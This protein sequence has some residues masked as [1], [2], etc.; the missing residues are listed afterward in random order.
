MHWGYTCRKDG[1]SSAFVKGV[2]GAICASAVAAVLSLGTAKNA[3]AMSEYLVWIEHLV[4]STTPNGAVFTEFLIIDDRTL[5]DALRQERAEDAV[6]NAHFAIEKGASIVS[7]SPS[8]DLDP[9]VNYL[10]L[11]VAVSFSKPGV[12]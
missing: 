2:G 8:E 10:P 9:N 11:D 3:A 12:F 7:S 5:L 4:A 6:I 1:R